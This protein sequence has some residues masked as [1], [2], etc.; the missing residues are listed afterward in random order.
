MSTEASD[1]NENIALID[2]REFAIS[3]RRKWMRLMGLAEAEIDQHCETSAPAD[4]DEE[5]E[6]L[7]AMAEI[8]ML[9]TRKNAR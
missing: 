4:L 2:P 5:L 3:V 8:R 9:N 1:M 6:N 7:F